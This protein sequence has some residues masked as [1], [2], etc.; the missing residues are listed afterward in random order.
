MAKTRDVR[1]V[2]EDNTLYHHFAWY[3]ACFMQLNLEWI[4]ILHNNYSS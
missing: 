3:V 4:I 1:V 2:N